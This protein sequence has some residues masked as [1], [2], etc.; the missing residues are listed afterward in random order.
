[1]RLKKP[2]ACEGCPLYQDGYGFV[3][4]RYVNSEV[5]ILAQNPGADEEAGERLVGRNGD[6]KILEPAPHQPL[7]GDTGYH[8]DRTWLPRAGLTRDEVSLTNAVRCRWKGTN[9]L[10][11]LSSALGR[12]IVQTCMTRHFKPPAETRVVMAMGDVA[13]YAA[14]GVNVWKEYSKIGDWRGW[15]LPFNPG[16]SSYSPTSIYTPGPRDRVVLASYHLAYLARAP[17]EEPTFIADWRKLGRVVRGEWPRALPRIETD[18]YAVDWEPGSAFDSEY[19]PGPNRLLRFSLATSSRVFVIEWEDVLRAGLAN[20][21]R[22]WFGNVQQNRGSVPPLLAGAEGQGKVAA[23]LSPQ[24]SVRDG[25]NVSHLSQA[26]S[27]APLEIRTDAFGLCLALTGS[28]WQMCDLP[29]GGY[30]AS[31]LGGRPRSLE[32]TGSQPALLQVQSRTGHVLRRPGHSYSGGPVLDLIFHNAVADLVQLAKLI[33]IGT[34]VL[35]NETM[36]GHHALWSDQEHTLDFISS[37]WGSINRSKHLE[38]TNKVAYAGGDAWITRD[39]WLQ[40]AKALEADPRSGRVYQ[41]YM[42]PLLPILARYEYG[43]GLKLHQGR[44][45]QSLEAL[46]RVKD[47]AQRKAWAAAGWPLKMSSPQQVAKQLFGVEGL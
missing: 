13:L 45:K 15:V 20:L 40:I 18:P 39:S 22:L 27:S 8:L 16:A 11:P 38:K 1:M 9:E 25:G 3:P 4:D 34:H 42:L 26:N 32:G 30:G 43:T 28:G 23:L 41:S 14:T 31:G 21:H 24:R 6:A 44:V 35:T 12:E 17:W 46:N 10:P 47:E 36:Y 33:P 29:Q 2:A 7:I 37:W 19:I 5:M